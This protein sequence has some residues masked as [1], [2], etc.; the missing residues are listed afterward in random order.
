MSLA[1]T[2][3]A[4]TFPGLSTYVERQSGVTRTVQGMQRSKPHIPGS[5]SLG[6]QLHVLQALTFTFE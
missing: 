6:H 5:V 2:L 4:G 1:S 3:L